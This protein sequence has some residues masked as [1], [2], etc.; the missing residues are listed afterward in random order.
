MTDMQETDCYYCFHDGPV[1]AYRHHGK[2]IGEQITSFHAWYDVVI[3]D[4]RVRWG[5]FDK[6][7]CR[8]H[9]FDIMSE[10]IE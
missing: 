5:R 10:G 3:E 2:L 1:A 8:R 7:H 4:S 6:G 9:D